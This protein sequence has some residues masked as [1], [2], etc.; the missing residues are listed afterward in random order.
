SLASLSCSFSIT[1]TLLLMLAHSWCWLDLHFFVDCCSVLFFLAVDTGPIPLKLLLCLLLLLLL[2]LPITSQFVLAALPIFSWLALFNSSSS[3][4]PSYR[5]KI[6]VSVLPSIE[7]I[8][9]GD[10]L[11]N[12][13]SV[14][15]SS[16]LDV[17]AWMPYGLIHFVAPFLVAILIFIKCPPKSLRVY[18]FSFGYMNLTGVLIQ[19]LFPCAPPWYKNLYG[20]NPA[21]YSINGS[22]AG[23]TRIDALFNL[24]LYSSSF[25]KSPMVFG[26]FPSLHSACAVNLALFLNHIFPNHSIYWCS[27]VLWIW[28]S[29]MYLNHHYFVDLIGGA[30]LSFL[31]Y[32]FST[33]FLMPVINHNIPSRWHYHKI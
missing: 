11:S 16:L 5:P 29:T 13:L 28:W 32:Y 1:N 10:D 14:H 17:L 9:Y 7:S 19:L 15:K 22:P 3:I 2:L 21:N 26:A 4:S 12:S 33:L 31:F 23:L 27:Y 8:L 6:Q 25:Q 20:L 18:A 30:I 24:N